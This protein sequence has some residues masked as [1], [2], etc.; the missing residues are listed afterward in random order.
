MQKKLLNWVV[1]FAVLI[2]LMLIV[3][4][5]SGGQLQGIM[6]AVFVAIGV[7]LILAIYLATSENKVWEIGTRQVVYMAL[8]A[9]LYGVFCWVFNVIPMP[10]VSQVALRPAVVIPIFFGYIFGPVVGFFTGAAGNILGDFLSGWG[11]YPAWDMG[12]GLM[13]FVPGLVLLFADKKRSLNTLTIITI[14]LLAIFAVLVF[15][16]PR[17]IGPW[18]G[19][20]EDFSFW[21]WAAL[22]A[23]GL[24]ILGRF[25]LERFNPDV[26]TAEVWGALGVIVGIGFASIADIW[27]NGYSLMTAIIGEFMPAAVPNI[28][29]MVILLPILLV[30]YFAVVRRAGR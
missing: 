14:A 30:A 27:I 5:A 11:V 16:N 22:I 29:N 12:N 28:L 24:V 13:G 15:V 26:A 25:L 23:G 19:E 8:G 20:I 2:A 10:S 3:N 7:V 17:V 4:V 21:A 1:L 6:W 18:T 9:A